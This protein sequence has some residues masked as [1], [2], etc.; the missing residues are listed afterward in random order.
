[1]SQSTKTHKQHTIIKTT[2]HTVN[3]IISKRNQKRLL[4]KKKK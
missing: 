1:M 3:G 2:D 4:K